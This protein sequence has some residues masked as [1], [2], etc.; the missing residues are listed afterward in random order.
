MSRRLERRPSDRLSSENA[1]GTTDHHSEKGDYA[2]EAYRIIER[3]LLVKISESSVDDC[4]YGTHR[5]SS[6]GH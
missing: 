1:I 2:Q 4:A 6:G 5:T 3:S